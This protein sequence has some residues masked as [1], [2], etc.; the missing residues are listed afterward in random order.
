MFYLSP[1][2]SWPYHNKSAFGPSSKIFIYTLKQ[3]QDNF[4]FQSLFWD[5]KNSLNCNTMQNNNK[6]TYFHHKVTGNIHYYSKRKEGGHNKDTMNQKENPTRTN[7][8][9][10]PI[11]NTKGFRRFYT[12]SCWLHTLAFSPGLVSL[13]MHRSFW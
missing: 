9:L 3:S 10:C 2:V 13:P 6:I 12:S 11:F 1:L 5:S 7:F 4:K 8:K